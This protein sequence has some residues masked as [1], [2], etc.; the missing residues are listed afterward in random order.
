MEKSH[1]SS[2]DYLISPFLSLPSKPQQLSHGDEDSDSYYVGIRHEL[3]DNSDCVII[4]N[5]LEEDNAN[6]VSEARPINRRRRF[7]VEDEDSDGDWANVESNSE[8]E[9]DEVE[10]LKDDDVVGKALQKCVKISADLRNELYESSAPA[11]SERYAEV[12][13]ASLKIVNQVPFLTFTEL[14][15]YDIIKACR[16]KDCDFQPILKPYQLVGVNFLLLLYQKGIGGAILADEMGLGKTIQEKE[17]M[18]WRLDHYKHCAFV[19]LELV[20][21]VASVSQVMIGI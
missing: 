12:E 20:V 13:A 6:K 2:S 16:S 7:V 1:S 3:E 14:L 8:E 15:V 17:Y 19:I 21:M 10:E 5:E 4:K 11:V 18:V 9:E